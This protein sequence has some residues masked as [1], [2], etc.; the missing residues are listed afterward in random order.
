MVRDVALVAAQ[1][2][3]ELADGRLAPAEGEQQPVPHRVAKRLE[4][5]GCGDRGN[6][7][8]LH[9]KRVYIS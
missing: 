5:L 1:R 6:V 8:L 9:E 4:L 7:V 3:G 2:H